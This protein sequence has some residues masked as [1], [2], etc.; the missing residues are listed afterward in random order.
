MF[1]SRS[2]GSRA[3]SQNSRLPPDLF[4]PA[5]DYS[6]VDGLGR[7]RQRNIEPRLNGQVFRAGAVG[8]LLEFI[9][10]ATSDGLAELRGARWFDEGAHRTLLDALTEMRHRW[11]QT[12]GLCGMLKGKGLAS[13]ESL[14]SFKIDAHKAALSANFG[15]AA[16][17][18][19]A[20]MGELIGNVIDHS[21]ADESGLAIFLARAGRFEL[22][23]ADRGVGV[24]RSLRQCPDYRTLGDE[25]AA[26]AAM[27]ETGVSRH[28]PG[29]GHGNGFRPIFERLANMTGQLRFRSGDYALSLDGQFGDRIGREISQKPGL[30]G[31]FAAVVCRIPG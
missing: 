8:P 17:L 10:L 25:G 23:V 18:L 30:S 14:A 28:G 26:L 29:Q 11:L 19:V 5:F 24:L 12:N 13:E 15:K 22:V 20:A 9:N 4:S 2:A 1:A 27:V 7:A 6:H 3:S 16:P 31:F 21:Q